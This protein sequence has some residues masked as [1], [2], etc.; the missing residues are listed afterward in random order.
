MMIR[1]RSLS[2]SLR[3]V[4]GWIET[5]FRLGEIPDSGRALNGL[6][7][8]PGSLERPVQ[9]V[10]TATDASL[11]TIH[12]A[13]AWEADLLVVHHGIGWTSGSI[14]MPD[15]DHPE[16][17]RTEALL[18]SN[19]AL[20]GLHLP[21]DVHPGMG[22][23]VELATALDLVPES[24][25]VPMSGTTDQATLAGSG[26]GLS[27][28]DDGEEEPMAGD[29]ATA[30]SS[31][32]VIRG[33]LA[34]SRLGEPPSAPAVPIEAHPERPGAGTVPI[35]LIARP[36]R[37]IS[38]G[39]LTRRLAQILNRDLPNSAQRN[40]DRV[41][42]AGI[43][44]AGVRL[45]PEAPSKVAVAKAGSPVHR[46]MIITGAGGSHIAAAA[47][48]GCD[49][50]ISGEAP[51]HAALLAEELGVGLLLGGHHATETGGPR[52]L[53]EWLALTAGDHGHRLHTRFI[54][55]PTGL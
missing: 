23:D 41:G 16:A 53:A 26:A 3:E 14:P 40:G 9:R 24:W 21:L 10:A 30:A 45:F 46:A 55:A 22:N 36:A 5:E 48:L 28:A 15:T 51:A 39:A 1:Q 49:L 8:L 27:T 34:S 38:R 50:L 43:G 4:L 29:E 47:E 19:M 35:G 25:A 33:H 2:A 31:H 11:R 18:W 6:Q 42:A 54:E 32:H 20:V 12:A 44:R 52:A 13:R 7:V 37:P 17:R